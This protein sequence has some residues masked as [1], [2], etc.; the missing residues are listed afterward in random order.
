MRLLPLILVT[1][2]VLIGYEK[3][4]GTSQSFQ[5]QFMF[6]VF[7]AMFTGFS[8]KAMLPHNKY[9]DFSTEKLREV[10]EYHESDQQP[11][12]RTAAVIEL[13]QEK[14]RRE[15]VTEVHEK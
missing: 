10:I 11:H 3:M 4:G 7:W 9:K 8:I 5:Q 15:G 6:L 12:A 2:V 13:K 14:A 1:V